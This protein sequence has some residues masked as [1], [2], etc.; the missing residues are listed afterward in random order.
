MSWC[1]TSPSFLE[2]WPPQFLPGV[3]SAEM[4]GAW[5]RNEDSH[6]SRT[7]FCLTGTFVLG[8]H[9]FSFDLRVQVR[10]SDWTSGFA[11]GSSAIDMETGNIPFGSKG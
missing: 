8:G 5:L 4:P 6:G 11:K 3:D 1:S 7:I 10:L 9:H 2:T